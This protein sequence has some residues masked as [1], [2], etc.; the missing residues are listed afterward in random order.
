MIP[1]QAHCV[2]LE[3]ICLDG[4]DGSTCLR[5]HLLGQTIASFHRLAQNCSQLRLVTTT[6]MALG[7]CLRCTHAGQGLQLVVVGHFWCGHNLL[8]SSWIFSHILTRLQSKTGAA[9]LA[10]RPERF[11]HNCPLEQ[12]VESDIGLLDKKIL[13]RQKSIIYHGF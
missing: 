3:P 4:I 8:T 1:S 6:T 10:I 5:V 11:M 12:P 13:V 9:S 7:V 2:L